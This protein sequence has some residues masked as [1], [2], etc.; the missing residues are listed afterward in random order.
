MT[1]GILSIN[2]WPIFNMVKKIKREG[3]VNLVYI[4][5]MGEIIIYTIHNNY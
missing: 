3:E 5:N 4:K 1:G 2:E